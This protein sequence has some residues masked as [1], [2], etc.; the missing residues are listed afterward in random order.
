M[1]ASPDLLDPRTVLDRA[2]SVLRARRAAEVDDLEVCLAWADLHGEAPAL[3]V[4]GGERLI[5]LGGDGT[6]TVRELCLAEL[7]IARHASAAETRSATADALDLRHRLPALWAATRGLECE[8]WLARKVARMSRRLSQRAVGVV[9]QAVT[10]AVH[11]SPARLI[12]IA[13]AKIIEADT[14]AHEAQ[15][16]QRRRERGVWLGR[17][18]PADPAHPDS[19]RAVQSLFAKIDPAAAYQLNALITQVAD[20]LAAHSDDAP[21]PE[22]DAESGPLSRDELRA[23]AL[24]LLARPDEVLDLINDD[25]STPDQP[26]AR[27]RKRD[28]AKVY[29]H[30]HESTLLSGDGLTRV[31]GLGPML[32]SHLSRLL[33]HADIELTPVV[34]LAQIRSVNGYEH[35]EHLKERTRLRLAVGDV[36]PHATSTNRRGDLD[37]PVPYDPGGPP[38]QTSDLNAAPLSRSSHRAKT[39]LGYTVEQL[40]L[41]RYLWRTPHGLLRLVD[42]TGTHVLTE[43]EAALLRRHRQPTAA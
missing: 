13:E 33:G 21:D 43:G 3:E 5:D 30:L 41:G 9:D 15:L 35:P 14:A 1:A 23:R 36:F 28:R 20:R 22:S 12:A 39:H 10:A 2:E 40:G 38:G 34:D 27:R 25:A 37:H 31:E 19:G 11:E 6:P 24:E 17:L 16:E 29:V 18:R 8:P 42:P 4:P 32:A 7:A 26:P